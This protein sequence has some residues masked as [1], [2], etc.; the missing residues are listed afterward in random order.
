MIVAFPSRS[1]VADTGLA[2]ERRRIV[3]IGAGAAGMTAA[4]H[5]GAHSVLIERRTQIGADTHSQAG[6]VAKG[7]IDDRTSSF[8]LGVANA[9]AAGAQD[10]GADRK[11]QGLSTWE[12]QAVAGA[13]TSDHR[14]AGGEGSEDGQPVV[15]SR[16][17]PPRLDPPDEASGSADPRE[18][19]RSLVPLLRGELRLGAQVTRIAPATHRIELA[20]GRSIVYDKLVSCVDAV[21][22]IGLLQPELPDRI[23]THQGLLYWLAARDVE[24]LDDST[25]FLYGDLDSFAAGRRVAETVKRALAQKFRPASES[26]VRG[27]KL[28][29]P[30][31]V[32]SSRT[33]AAAG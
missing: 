7:G 16:W 30:R 17:I 14:E 2:P 11:R 10:R 23:R 24:L 1:D 3:I 8:P 19:L 28:F 15:I 26:F 29:T 25:Q 6:L 12:R 32:R 27:E 21:A 31:L 22:L 9:G 13:C 18:S 20:D 4:L 5:I 33:T